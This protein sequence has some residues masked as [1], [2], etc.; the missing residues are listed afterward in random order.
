MPRKKKVLK[1]FIIYKTTN[2]I[3]NRFYI[4]RHA[5][6]RLEDG[7]LG[8]GKALR[9][10]IR[11]YGK[12]NH[13]REILEF[14]QN[15]EELIMR[16]SEIVTEELLKNK[17][18]MNLCL[19]GGGIMPS[20]PNQGFHGPHHEGTKKQI[21]KFF[22]GKKYED[23]H[24]NPELERKKRADGVKKHWDSMTEEQKEL[25]LAK[26]RKTLIH[27]KGIKQKSFQCPYCL[28]QGGNSMKRWHF[29]RCKNKTNTLDKINE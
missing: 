19:G 3:N 7:Y 18:C 15:Q 24:E 23:F 5:T 6:P 8:S 27:T 21:S 10:S 25:R 16:E 4:G 11:K 13:V 29:D 1:Y 22:S 17:S 12:E 2:I 28:K 14:C 9:R 20:T 26:I